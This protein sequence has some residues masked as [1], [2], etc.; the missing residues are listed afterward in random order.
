[1]NYVKKRLQLKLVS[2]E[3]EIMVPEYISH[4]YHAVKEY[5]E[6]QLDLLVEYKDLISLVY[7]DDIDNINE[8]E[9]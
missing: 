5:A 3:I 9:E 6:I 2:D 7:I 1:M 8:S 4:Q